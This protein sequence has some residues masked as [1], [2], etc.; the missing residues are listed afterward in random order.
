MVDR[1]LNE[2]LP[3]DQFGRAMIAPGNK[4]IQAIPSYLVFDSREKGK[5][6]FPRF[7]FRPSVRPIMTAETWV[8]ADTIEALAAAINVPA[9]KLTTT[10]ERFNDFAKHGVDEDFA[11]GEDP[12][13]LFF[14]PP[15]NSGGSPTLRC[16]GFHK[17]RSTPHGSFSAI[18]AQRAA[19]GWTPTRVFF[20]R[21]APPST[22][23]RAGNTA[24]SLTGQP[25]ARYFRSERQ[26]CF[27]IG[28]SNT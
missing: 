7:R 24:A 11:R 25:R 13:D 19:S 28:Q 26:W 22:A 1:Y 3:Y 27:P 12:Y 17:D 10:V 8:R 21:M 5:A 18:S 6:S 16:M 20:D 23:L 4:S 15:S 14:C 9:A 2:S